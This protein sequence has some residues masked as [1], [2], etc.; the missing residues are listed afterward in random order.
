M[1]AHHPGA[2]LE[3]RA[4]VLEG[5]PLDGGGRV[6]LQ[7]GDIWPQEACHH[8]DI[9]DEEEEDEDVERWLWVDNEGSDEGYRDLELF[10]DL[11]EDDMLRGRLTRAIQCRGAFHRFKGTLSEEPML[12]RRWI[13][14]SDERQRGR[15]IARVPGTRGVKAALITPL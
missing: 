15:S 10:I 11:V 12:V 14:F 8:G 3:E 7:S 4:G 13:T 5:D 9:D 2:A 6:D 1:T